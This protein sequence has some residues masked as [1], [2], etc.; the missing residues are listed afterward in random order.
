M[1]TAIREQVLA[2]FETLLGTVTAENVAGTITVYR[3]RRA[4]VPEEMLPAL[5]MR[6]APVS[7]DQASAAVVRN[8]ER[9]T[10]TAV[11]TETTDGDLDKALT[12]LWAALLRAVEADPTLGGLAVDT[13]LAK[14]DPDAADDG[15]LAG[16]AVGGV[17]DIA[18]A[19]I[20]EYWTRPG[21]PYALAP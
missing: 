9:I 3:G 20:V 5:V 13:T 11:A 1:T 10:V 2:A 21:D 7:A 15:G 16:E 18:T 14:A 12:D 17:G 6:A 19:F 8:L 4:A